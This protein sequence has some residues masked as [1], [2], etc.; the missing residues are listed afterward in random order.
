[1]LRPCLLDT[2]Y[3]LSIRRL[4]NFQYWLFLDIIISHLKS[5]G[6]RY[7]TIL[8]NFIL[9]VTIVQ[10]GYTISIGHESNTC[11][12]ASYIAIKKIYYI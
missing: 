12:K 5:E 2:I 8:Q 10:F 3:D 1:M 6:S 4:S 11:Q 9:N 7:Y